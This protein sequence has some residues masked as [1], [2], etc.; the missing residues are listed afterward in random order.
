MFRPSQPL[1]LLSSLG[2]VLLLP[3]DW[4]E[5]N[6]TRRCRA[7]REG[8]KATA[9]EKAAKV[10]TNEILDGVCKEPAP[11]KSGTY[12]PG[13]GT[14][15]H[16]LGRQCKIDDSGHAKLWPTESRFAILYEGEVQGCIL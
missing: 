16:Q 8:A 1:R 14:C 9:A 12:R 15:Q 13:S 4:A 11:R 7:S 3:F 5:P 2:L 10:I 6:L